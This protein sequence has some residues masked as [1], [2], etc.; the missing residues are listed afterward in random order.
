[1]TGCAGVSVPVTEPSQTGEARRLAGSMARALGFDETLAGKVTIAVAESAANLVKHA[2]G[3]EVLLCRS[4]E[5]LEAIALNSGPGIPDLRLA[6]QDGYSTAGSVGIGLGSMRRLASEFDIYS[7]PGEGCIVRM[8]F[9]QGLPTPGPLET[10]AVSVAKPG[11]TSNGDAFALAADKAFLVDGLGH[12]PMAAEAAQAAIRAFRE[13]AGRD[14]GD[15]LDAV[16]A[17][18]RP[19]RGAAAAVTGFDRQN[20]LAHYAGVGNISGTILAGG[21]SR[22]MVSMAGIAGHQLTRNSVFT[23]PWPEDSLTVLHS[24]GI[25]TRWDLARYPGILRHHPSVIAAV[26]YRD[27]RRRNDDATV[28]VLRERRGDA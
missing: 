9:R 16:H 1:M 15:V 21:Q 22:S 7:A 26:L 11:E 13:N 14:T 12:G 4:G 3:G 24:D 17:A 6:Q 5:A 8:L 2:G 19:T 28:F 23:Y 10:G 20:R 25:A 27:F 18:L